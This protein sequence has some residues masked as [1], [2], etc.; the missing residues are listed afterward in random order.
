[1]CK[2]LML[3]CAVAAAVVGGGVVYAEIFAG[4]WRNNVY[5]YTVV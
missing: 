2:A 3:R 5:L 1:M 4:A